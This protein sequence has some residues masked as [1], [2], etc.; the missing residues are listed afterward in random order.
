MGVFFWQHGIFMTIGKL[1]EAT[2]IV[3]DLGLIYLLCD[4]LAQSKV[5]YEKIFGFDKADKNLLNR[6]KVRDSLEN[7]AMPKS[8]FSL[9]DAFVE[10]DGKL[11]VE[12]TQKKITEW[13][14]YVMFIKVPEMYLQLPNDM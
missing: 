10:F 7:Y 14:K 6:A 12:K 13:K 9:L 2:E 3:K 5:Q 1:A 4:Y 11:N 8:I